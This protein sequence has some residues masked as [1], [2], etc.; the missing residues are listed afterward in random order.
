MPDSQKV[1]KLQ[2]LPKW[3]GKKVEVLQVYSLHEF[4]LLSFFTFSKAVRHLKKILAKSQENCENFQMSG[5]MSSF[6]PS[7][8]AT[9]KYELLYLFL[10]LKIF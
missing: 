10:N 5:K 6:I 4:E 2:E 8:L 7:L 1:Q 9:S 3:L